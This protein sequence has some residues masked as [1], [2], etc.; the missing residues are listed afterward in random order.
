MAEQDGVVA[1]F[2]VGIWL[3]AR[4]DTINEVLNMLGVRLPAE[5]G[6]DKLI[7]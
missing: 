6:V 7:V 4:A 1:L 3:F 5:F 2:G